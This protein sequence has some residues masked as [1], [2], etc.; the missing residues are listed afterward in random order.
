MPRLCP[1][2]AP[3]GIETFKCILTTRQTRPSIAPSGIETFATAAQKQALDMTFNR[4][5]GYWN[6]KILL[7]PRTRAALQSHLRVLK[8]GVPHELPALH[9]SFNRTFGYW[10]FLNEGKVFVFVNLQSHLRVLKL[11]KPPMKS[12]K[13][14]YLQS[15]LRVLKLV[16]LNG[17]E[18]QTRFPSIAPSGIETSDDDDDNDANVSFNRTFGYWNCLLSNRRRLLVPLQSHL[19]VLKLQVFIFWTN[20]Q[21]AFNRTFGY[22]NFWWPTAK[23]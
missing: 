12:L 17:Y 11:R 4:T 20:A 15:H 2:I 9:L 3:S 6:G 19:R 8:L 10:N 22:W 7:G 14:T 16:F 5:F 21:R 23:P 13:I 1:S 18:R